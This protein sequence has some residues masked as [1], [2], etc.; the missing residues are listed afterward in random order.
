MS[1]LS[2][3]NVKKNLIEKANQICGTLWEPVRFDTD[4]PNKWKF[5]FRS[6]NNND[7]YQP[8]LSDVTDY[9]MTFYNYY[10]DGYTNKFNKGDHYIGVAECW[11]HCTSNTDLSVSA[12][13]DDY[14]V[15]YLNDELQFRINKVGGWETGTI[16]FKQGWN[17][18]QYIF[19]EATGE[20]YA[21]I[22]KTLH[23]QSFIDEMYAEGKEVDRRG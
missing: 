12:S 22:N 4:I 16:H 2:D 14:G 15:I 5:S 7:T 3:F 13:N 11:I 17:H 8:V 9:P 19:N 18:L 21:Y 6:A 23:T 1:L 10:D 20:D